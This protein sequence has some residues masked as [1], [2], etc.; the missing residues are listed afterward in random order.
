VAPRCIMANVDGTVGR[1]DL[2]TA[3]LI[4]ASAT[5]TTGAVAEATS[6]TAARAVN[7]GDTGAAEGADLKAAAH[8]RVASNTAAGNT[9]VDDAGAENKVP[10]AVIAGVV[11]TGAGAHNP[12][13]APSGTVAVAA[14]AITLAV[15]AATG[16]TAA[17][18]AAAAAPAVNGGRIDASESVYL[19]AAV[20]IVTAVDAA[21]SYSGV[22]S[23]G[24]GQSV[25]AAGNA[26]VVDTGAGTN[27]LS[28]V[29]TSTAATAA[30]A[31][32]AGSVHATKID[33]VGGDKQPA[34]AIAGTV[35][36]T[37]AVE[38]AAI[39]VVDNC[40]AEAAPPKRPY[41]GRSKHDRA[42][43]QH[44]RRK[45]PFVPKAPRMQ[46][47]RMYAPPP[48]PPPR[49]RVTSGKG[50]KRKAA[51]PEWSADGPS[52]APYSDGYSS[53]WAPFSEGYPSSRQ[54]KSSASATAGSSA[55]AEESAADNNASVPAAEAPGCVGRGKAPRS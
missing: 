41:R 12:A 55:A 16:T 18:T 45:A 50:K 8:T 9:G 22:L 43:P 35:D 21:A 5:G 26:G 1:D 6:A 14:A 20:P 2:L 38:S 37:S 11:D 31:A 30:A 13:T 51:T 24:V 49:K 52:R 54:T 40:V 4:G 34:A 3:A 10:A 47:A 27:K 46:V 42:L 25:L 17:V 33:R 44:H 15:N 53:S 29:P 39:E 48:S 36:A 23:S 7:G 28:T 32:T 19:P